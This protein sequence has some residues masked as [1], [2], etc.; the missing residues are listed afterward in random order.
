LG[1]LRNGNSMIK[2]MSGTNCVVPLVKVAKPNKIPA[3]Q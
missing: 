1:S 2:K 3:A